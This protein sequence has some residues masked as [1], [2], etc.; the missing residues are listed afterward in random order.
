MELLGF[1]GWFDIDDLKE[2]SKEAIDVAVADCATIIVLLNDETID[3][4]WCRHEWAAAARLGLPTKVLVDLQRSD[5]Q[6]LL[7][8][9]LRDFPELCHLQCKCMRAALRKQC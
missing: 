9:I 5:K 4:E 8:R 3:S 2:I 7:Q 1:N 6:S